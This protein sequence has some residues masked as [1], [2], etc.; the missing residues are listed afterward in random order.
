MAPTE[1][2]PISLPLEALQGEW[3]ASRG[4]VIKVDGADLCINGKTMP[5]GL[6]VSADGRSAVGFGIYK[7]APGAQADGQVAWLA[8]FQEILWRRPAQGEVRARTEFMGARSRETAP[9]CGG[10]AFDVASEQDAVARLNELMERWREGPP[11]RVRSCDICPDWT[12]RAETGLSVDHVHYVATMIATNGF[13]SRRRGLGTEDGAHDV[14]ILVRE[15]AESELGRG[16]L[17]KWREAVAETKGFPPFFLEGRREFFCSLGNGHFS[18]ALNLF[19]AGAPNL[20]TETPYVVGGDD[21]LREALDDGVESVVL[22]AE[23]PEKDRRFV[24]E[25]LNRSH[26]R[27]W[28]V[29]DDG[30]V[31]IQEEGPAALAGSQFVA[32]SKVLD[33]EELSC[34]VR[35]KLGVDV[36]GNP[37]DKGQEFDDPRPTE[38]DAAAATVAADAE[39]S[40]L[41]PARALQAAPSSSQRSR[42]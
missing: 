14:P 27:R 20:W 13:K 16:A 28:Q 1:G 9:T 39:S 15:G 21:A 10:Q 3:V 32:L 22:S 24:S 12:N 36:H 17:G 40:E 30:R 33:A 34:L 2:E 37:V 23:M 19:R 11:V 42:L 4:E 26:G 41:A 18:Q 5:G 7:L 38:A 35:Q 25:M 8:G 6:K 29:G 31:R